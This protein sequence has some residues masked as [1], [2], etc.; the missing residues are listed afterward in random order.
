MKIVNTIT[1]YFRGVYR[2]MAK[3]VWPTR[4]QAINN[5]LLV[6]ISVVAA[7]LVFSL[8][9]LGLSSL[10]GFYVQGR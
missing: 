2:E 9:D 1:G 5:T 7:A 4:R 6:I 10:V 3:V 8:L